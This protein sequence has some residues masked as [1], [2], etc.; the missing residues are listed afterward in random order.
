MTPAGPIADVRWRPWRIP[1][2]DAL[3]TGAGELTAREGLVVRI[4]TADG[5]IGLGESAPLPA[6]GLSVGALAARVA[7]VGQALMGRSPVD[8]WPLPSGERVAGA[9]VGIQTALADLLAESCGVPLANW[10]AGSR[11]GRSRMS[12]QCRCTTWVSTTSVPSWLL[13][14]KATSWAAREDRVPV[15]G[16]T[17]RVNAP[18]SG[19]SR[20]SARLTITTGRGE[21]SSSS[22]TS[23]EYSWPSWRPATPTQIAP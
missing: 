13:T 16:T 22:S 21:C 7:E 20:P 1:L 2:R 5:A 14:P 19:V 3:M 17:A 18:G 6:E 15:T 9:D 12:G 10:L 8:A 4:E 23:G 11:W